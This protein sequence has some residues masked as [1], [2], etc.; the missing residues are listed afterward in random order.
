MNNVKF[1]NNIKVRAGYGTTGNANIGQFLYGSSITPITTGVGTGFSVNNFP[2]PNLTWET[3]RQADIGLDFSILNNRIDASADWYKK[4]SKNFLF[5]QPLPAFLAGGIAEYSGA[6]IVQPPEVNAG[7]IQNTG[8]EFT[9][10]SR[11]IVHKDFSWTTNV[12][13]SAYTNKVISL[14]GFP[15]LLGQIG[16]GGGALINVTDTH[17]GD[18]VGEFYGYKVQGII[19]TQAELDQLAAHPQNVTGAPSVVTNSRNVANGVWFGDVAYEGTDPKGNGSNPNPQYRLGN[20]NPKFTYSMTNA[21]KYKDFDF[22][23][24]IT[25]VY[26]DKILNA[27]KFQTEALDGLYSNQLAAAGNFWTP[28]NQN[29]NIPTPRATF[30]NNNLVMSDRFIESGS[31][32]RIQNMR[33]GYTLP[34]KYARVA[35]FNRLKAYISGQN[36]WVIT[37]YSG[38]DPEVGSFNQNP[39]LTNVDNGRYPSPR[40]LTF[41]INAEF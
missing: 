14:N 38:L 12:I 24:F 30:G 21:F 8:Y 20:P 40:V 28:Q 25:G 10:T 5:Q 41:G 37:K 22:T 13:Y 11:N 35:K 1:A 18:P 6:A 23:I 39:I 36:L 7:E 34:V 19:S 29:T 16:S 3:A 15:A 32:L 4:T 9:I 26:G 2:N 17:A 31:Y 27:L 33:L